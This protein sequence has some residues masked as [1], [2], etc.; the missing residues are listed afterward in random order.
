MIHA[1]EA[2]I[3]WQ[4]ANRITEQCL[5]DNLRDLRRQYW[6]RKN[7]HPVGIFHIDINDDL[8]ELKKRI[9]AFRVVR[10]YIRG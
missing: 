6:R 3:T 5:R 9:D 10:E 7:G 8:Q 4:S 2:T 1:Y